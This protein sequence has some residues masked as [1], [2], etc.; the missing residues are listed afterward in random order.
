MFAKFS[1]FEMPLFGLKGKI[2]VANVDPEASTILHIV[3][4]KIFNIPGMAKEVESVREI[5]TLVVEPIDVDEVS[6]IK[7]GPVR[8]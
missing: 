3:W 4:I 1:K 7:P 8:V 6:L 5:A 2:E